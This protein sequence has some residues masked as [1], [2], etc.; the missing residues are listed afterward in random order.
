M[1]QQRRW[2]V[3]TFGYLALLGACMR[4]APLLAPG[5]TI[6]VMTL[7][8]AVDGIRSINEFCNLNLF[9]TPGDTTAQ[10]GST[11]AECHAPVPVGTRM[12]VGGAWATSTADQ[13]E[14]NW[15]P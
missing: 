12:I 13:R 15:E 14:T 8:N 11:T 3:L 4:S 9:F 5:D 1:T 7:S 10:P 6:G 2:I